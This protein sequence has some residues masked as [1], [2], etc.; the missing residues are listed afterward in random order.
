M[1]DELSNSNNNRSCCNERS[2]IEKRTMCLLFSTVP[3]IIG[4]IVVIAIV[5]PENHLYIIQPV[6]DQR[7]DIC[8]TPGCVH[9]ASDIMKFID[10][11]I[12]PCND[13]YQFACGTFLNKTII[14]D[15][16]TQVTSFTSIDNL[17]NTQL[18]K[19]F[20]EN[21]TPSEPESFKHLKE[22]YRLC[23]N[24]SDIE[25]IGLDAIKG[26]VLDLGGW[27][28]LEGK[29]WK[30]NDF[31]WKTS[32]LNF[33][34]H[35]LSTSNFM[36]FSVQPDAKNSSRNLIYIDQAELELSRENWLNGFEDEIIKAYYNYLVELAV[37]FGADKR[38]A[39]Y[40]VQTLMFFKQQLANI[41]LPQE[42]RRDDTAL[43]N[44]MT[45][46]ELQRRHPSINWSEVINNFVDFPDKVIENDEIVVVNVPQY[47]SGFED[48]L[49]KTSK[50]VLANHAIF[51]AITSL[52]SFLPEDIRTIYQTLESKIYGTTSSLPRWEECVTITTDI[53]QIAAASV[54][55]RKYFDDET[56]YK[57]KDIIDS[58]KKEFIGTLRKTEWMDEVTRTKAIDKANAM[59]VYVG[60]PNEL[61]DNKKINL[62]YK[63]LE[64]DYDNYLNFVLNVT[65]FKTDKTIEQLWKINN[66]T[67]WTTHSYSTAVN[68]FYDSSE[69]SM[70][71][72][73]AILQGGFFNKDRPQCLNYGAIG[74][75]IGHEITH[76]FDDEGKQYDKEGNLIN[77]WADET[78]TAFKKKA[79]CIINQYGNQITNIGIK[80]NGL[81]TQGENIAD[82]GG[83]KQAYLAYQTW[84]RNN[85]EEYK[86]PGINYTTNQ[87]FWISAAQ[88]WCTK[89]RPE[90]LKQD[91][92]TDVHSPARYRVSI[93]FSNTETFASD[94]NC[95]KGSNMNPRH[96]CKV[97]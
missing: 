55:V 85:T 19:A 56:K 66:K 28:I 57:A 78:D 1:A 37:L 63:N 21:V 31:D 62:Y 4:L 86:L 61:L 24:T 49:R 71:F 43:Y 44:P 22:F 67:D 96:K 68:A 95:R 17:V 3:V 69:N 16:K 51:Q 20:E 59:N 81:N 88:Q 90:S 82:N 30:E 26:I 25:M 8:Q 54:Y 13:F 41:S 5:I 6:E 32:V 83:I 47:L 65:I 76:G 93:S 7:E 73:A 10:T 23:M 72:P 58:V 33:R 70:Q 50:R 15:D 12:D 45:I 38:F 11:S 60:Y 89:Q 74:A 94:F 18:K 40:E 77:W 27:P 75:I 91:I 2:K 29:T 39:Q 53:L 52:E 36:T 92:L 87:L 80:L 84:I 14:P 9:A 35:G 46:T 97:W 42:Q 79:L 34:Q 48:L 64:V